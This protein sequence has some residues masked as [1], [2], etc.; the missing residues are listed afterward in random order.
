MADR[1]EIPPALRG[2]PQQQIS[3]ISSYLFRLAEGLNVAF[4]GMQSSGTPSSGT[5]IMSMSQYT[6]LRD[7][8]GTVAKDMTKGIENALKKAEESG[9]F[10]GN[11]I[12]SV[13]FNEDATITFF[14]TDG[15][16][17]TTPVIKGEPGEDYVLTEEDKEEIA[18]MVP[19]GSGGSSVTVSPDAP[20]NPTLGSLWYDTDE[21]IVAAQDYV[22][23]S[24]TS[25]IWTYRKWNSGL[26]ECWGTYITTGNYYSGPYAGWFYGYQVNVPYPFTFK[27]VKSGT[28]NM[29][30]GSGFC[31]SCNVIGDA[32]DSA[33]CLG[34]SNVN[35]ANSDIAIMLHVFGTWK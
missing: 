12:A 20:E 2:E 30:V 26:A 32:L 27:T 34:L 9:E 10:D 29:K 31:A 21:E 6:E 5:A 28:H 1:V 19:G 25:G 8:I 23:E 17:F 16:E 14:F 33:T 35:T 13:Q 11:G 4:D 7:M 24:G 18:G 15:T 3:Q 22:V